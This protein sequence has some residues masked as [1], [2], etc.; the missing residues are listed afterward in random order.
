MKKNNLI[1]P[2]LLILIFLLGLFLRLYRLSLNIPPLYA[3]ETGQYLLRQSILGHTSGIVQQLINLSITFTWFLGLSPLGARLPS[4]IYGALLI[5]VAYFFSLGFSRGNI[6]V[7]LLDAFLIAILPWSY[8]L[9]RI[10]HSPVQITLLLTGLHVI[11]FSKS[12]KIRDY[13]ISLIPL[14]V[15]LLYY[16]SILFILPFIFV[17]FIYIIYQSFDKKYRRLFLFLFTSI[18][19][20]FGIFYSVKYNLFSNSNRGL[21]MAIWRDVNTPYQIDK[22]R[23]LSWNSQPTL[24]SFNLP[25]EK[26]ANKLV[27]N[28]AMAYISTFS[29][30]YFSFFSADW[31]FLQ[32]DTTLRHSTGQMG[33]FLPVLAP[34]ML[35]GAYL[36]F[37]SANGK[38]KTIFLIWILASPISAAITKDG[39]GYLLR[40]VTLL[41]FLTYFSALGVVNSFSFITRV[42]RIPYIILLIILALY[43]AYYFFYGYFQVYPS[44]S[45]RSYEYGFKELSDFQVNHNNAS[46]LVIWDGY[47]H[48]NDFRFWQNTSSNQLS[49]FK[50]KQLSAGESGFTQTFSNLYFVKPKTAADV[51]KFIKQNSIKFVVFPDRYYINYPEQLDKDFATPSA[52][53]RYPDQSPALKIFTIK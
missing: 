22:Y 33:A 27:Y 17:Y 11:L 48:N 34:F 24:F 30:N 19:V 23:A 3:D 26:L 32:G 28:R 39:A 15:S 47:Y 46:M 5:L 31:L 21:D 4:A 51:E 29:H 13:F 2:L 36:F 38:Q 7:A 37:K 53:I 42:W 35:Y 10:G 12:T 49:S 40:M 52:V 6:K 20:A 41:P 16:P 18:A 25:P 43:S 44:L 50:L 14:A 1:I 45:A 9:S 8:M